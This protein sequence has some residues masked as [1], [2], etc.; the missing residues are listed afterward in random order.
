MN[1]SFE[2]KELKI[3]RKSVDNAKSIL[4]RKLAQS[5]NIIKTVL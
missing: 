5:N 3:L 1:E 4:G 2:E